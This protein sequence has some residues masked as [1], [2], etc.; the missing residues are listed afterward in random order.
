[1]LQ[2]ERIKLTLNESE[3]LLRQKAA[4][5]LR[6]SPNDIQTLSILRRS[7]DAR[8]GIQFV[9]TLRVQVKN[10]KDVL[11]RCRSWVFTYARLTEENRQYLLELLTPGMFQFT[12]PQGESTCYC[13]EI[14]SNFH[15][16]TAGV[17]KDFRFR[18]EEV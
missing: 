6:V 9:Y 2:I 17:W 4:A 16:A 13:K 18:V 3:S 12:H 14:S 8:D 5:A 15:D 7:V 10:E 11:R 1:M